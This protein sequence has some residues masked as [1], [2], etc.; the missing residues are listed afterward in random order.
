M[1]VLDTREMLT[2]LGA[3]SPSSIERQV[4]LTTHYHDSVIVYHPERTD[5]NG[6]SAEL[7]IP[8]R[9]LEQ[10]L[11]Q[12]F[13]LEPKIDPD[14]V[15]GVSAQE[16]ENERKEARQAARTPAEVAADSRRDLTEVASSPAASGIPGAVNS[17]INE[18]TGDAFDPGRPVDPST[19]EPVTET[20]AER[21]KRVAAAA[22]EQ[23]KADSKREREEKAEAKAKA[24]AQK[25]EERRTVPSRR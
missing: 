21:E 17:P 12:G 23:E 5:D 10:K 3:M 2:K 13:T 15:D 22:K 19:G 18:L 24:E 6:R 16:L 11:E 1:A 14:R 7:V 20:E 4:L 25:A 8:V 9:M